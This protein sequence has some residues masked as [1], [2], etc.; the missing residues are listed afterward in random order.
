MSNKTKNALIVILLLG[1]AITNL[2]YEGANRKLKYE[3]KK[4][5]NNVIALNDEVRITKNKVNQLEYNRRTF[6]VDRIEE[7]EALNKN[8]AQEVK[9]TKGK[10]VYLQGSKITVKDT[11]II[12][13]SVVHDT[14]RSIYSINGSFDTL[15]SPGNYRAVSYNVLFDPNDSVATAAFVEEFGMSVITGLKKNAKKDYEILFRSQFPGLKSVALEGA[16]I[17]RNQL[18]KDFKRKRLGVGFQLGYH[19]LSYDLD[20]K[21]FKLRNQISAGVGVSYKF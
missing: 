1:I 21:G 2:L 18:E 14:A 17:P 8:L 11:I 5:E 7:L 9:N 20:A 19:P 16:Y 6:I 3:N 10:V 15:Y 4:L 12:P 13:G